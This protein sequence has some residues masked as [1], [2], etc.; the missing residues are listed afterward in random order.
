[1]NPEQA[2]V[3]QR[4]QQNVRFANLFAG[5]MLGN[6]FERFSCGLVSPLVDLGGDSG[7]LLL[8]S[9][10]SKGAMKID[11]SGSIRSKVGFS[12]Q[13]Q[14]PAG[15]PSKRT[16]WCP[17]GSGCRSLI[18]CLIPPPSSA[19]WQLLW[20]TVVW[21]SNFGRGRSHPTPSALVGVKLPSATA[22]PRKIR[23]TELLAAVRHVL[24]IPLLDNL[25]RRSSSSC[26][27]RGTSA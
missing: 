8:E 26:G 10:S 24:P 22:R 2:Q 20:A 14:F 1:M 23:P 15:A 4:L 12:G 27:G 21:R 18:F 19:L 9:Y 5:D 6:G 16:K 13:G 25:L 7:L 11:E 17:K 3:S